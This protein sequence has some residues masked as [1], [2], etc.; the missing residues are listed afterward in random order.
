MAI[1][2]PNGFDCW[3]ETYFECTRHIIE[4]VNR[5]GSFAY[6]A[7]EEG[8]TGALWELSKEL[9]NEFEQLNTDVIWGEELQ[10]FDELE[11]FFNEKQK[12]LA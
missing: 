10:F 1:E 5:E 7:N 9:A 12:Q 3:I 4:T 11:E 8:G 6:K 2:F